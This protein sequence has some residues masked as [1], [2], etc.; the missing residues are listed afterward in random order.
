MRYSIFLLAIFSFTISAQE[1]DTTDW[2]R[3]VPFEVGNEWQFSVDIL[4]DEPIP[5]YE[6]EYHSYE[7]LADSLIDG[8]IHFVFRECVQEPGSPVICDPNPTVVRVDEPAASVVHRVLIGGEPDERFW[9]GYPCGLD[10]PF[11]DFLE[12][13]ECPGGEQREYIITGGYLS[14]EMR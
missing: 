1:P 14:E 7:I 12:L 3:Y 13:I 11:S 5:V 4:Q 8:H 10:A 9:L 6:T 2:H